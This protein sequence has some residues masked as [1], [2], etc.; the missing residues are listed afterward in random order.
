M[1]DY[2]NKHSI[3]KCG[4]CKNIIKKC[5]CGDDPCGLAVVLWAN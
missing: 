5:D 2:T 1:P 3:V 4:K